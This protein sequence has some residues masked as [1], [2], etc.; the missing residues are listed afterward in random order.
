MR[1][2]LDSLLEIRLADAIDILLVTSL[3][4]AGIVWIRRTQAG[5][6]AGGIVIL[7]GLYIAAQSI[8]LQLTAWLLQGFFAIFLI[9]VVVIF[10]EELRQL[11]ERLALFSLRRNRRVKPPAGIN[12]ILVEAM[13]DLARDRI[14]ALVVLQCEQPLRRHVRGG[15]E[16]GAKLSVPL[17]KSIFDPH[18]PGHD[19]AV[20]VENGRIALFAAHLPLSTNFQQLTGVGTRHSAA[21][22]LAELTDALCLLVSEERGRISVAKDGTLATLRDANELARVLAA[23]LD[24]RQPE[25]SFRRTV[26]Q[27]LFAN[28]FTRLASL[29]VVL[30][31][32]LLFVPG[33]RPSE[34]IL[35]MP[36]EVVNLPDGA[37]VESI[38]PSEVQAT[39]AGPQ[40]AFALLTSR[41]LA[42]TIDA[43]R[44]RP[45]Q[46]TFAIAEENLRHPPSLSVQNLQPRRVK[47][48]LVEVPTVPVPAPTL[49]GAKA[50]AG[51]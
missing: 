50:S 23:E 26:R 4:Y 20:I 11:F 37:Q 31:M 48:T 30:G 6:V 44:A 27:L 46:K 43:R 47:V 49:P 35:R 32:W 16:M 1:G 18:S 33:S 14:G 28:W 45:G 25:R 13:A 24:A 38:E 39:F 10:Q 42:V 5:L 12:D 2:L 17:L 3:V 41:D 36:V 9:I 22:G 40:R 29:A 8:G 21:L 19:G 34:Q 7:G 15:I 51:D